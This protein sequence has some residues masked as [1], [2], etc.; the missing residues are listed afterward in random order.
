[1]LSHDK[2]ILYG[3]DNGSPRFLS[4]SN[5]NAQSARMESIISACFPINFGNSTTSLHNLGVS[6]NP[7]HSNTGLH[8]TQYVGVVP[9]S[10]L[11]KKNVSIPVGSYIVLNPRF[12]TSAVTMLEY[13]LRQE[14]FLKT[15]EDFFQIH[16]KN[17]GEW[18]D[19]IQL[20]HGND[21]VFGVFRDLPPVLLPEELG[22]E[23]WGLGQLQNIFEIIDFLTHCKKVCKH[24][25]RQQFQKKQENLT[26]KVRGKIKI[27]EQLKQNLNHGR[28]DRNVCE[29]HTLSQNTVENQILKYTLSL[30]TKQ[31]EQYPNIMEEELS[32]CA[33]VLAPIPN[34]RCSLASFSGLKSNSAY[35][36]YKP[37][38]ASAKKLIQ[39]AAFTVGQ[40]AI[41][42]TP[43]LPVTPF[44][45]RMDLLFELYCRALVAHVIQED[46]FENSLILTPYKKKYG[47]FGEKKFS[48]AGIFMDNM[49]P[50]I[51]LEKS[52]EKGLGLVL[53]A[54]YSSVERQGFQTKR[55]RT[56]Q[57]LAYMQLFQAKS[58]GLMSPFLGD[59]SFSLSLENIRDTQSALVHLP[60]KTTTPLESEEL[61]R[62]LL[63]KLFLESS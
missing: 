55:E 62:E 34:V 48:R 5:G 52:G 22:S 14:D 7:N 9:L 63:C 56:H 35:K 19:I 43:S 51:L 28:L 25:L 41:S 12:K 50:D 33:K 61:V 44:F 30:V 18:E 47:V 1:M 26:G 15:H 6:R 4:N 8:S 24:L 46:I 36:Y 54:K 49:D 27:N 3:T 42:G 20:G 38:L 11:P 16:S 29:F 13:I 23:C 31:L 17:Q 32:F 58:G 60:V 21:V 37:A 57:I 2:L 45:L 53:D 39:K 10:P 59:T 40:G